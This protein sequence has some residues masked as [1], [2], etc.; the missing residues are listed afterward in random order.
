MNMPDFIKENW[1]IKLVSL[2]IALIV[3]YLSS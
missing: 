2:V 3:F 1:E